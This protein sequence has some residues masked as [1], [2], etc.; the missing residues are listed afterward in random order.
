VASSST[1]PFTSFQN[2]ITS[3]NCSFPLNVVINVGYASDLSQLG[4]TSIIIVACFD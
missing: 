4:A 3:S 1:L 2:A